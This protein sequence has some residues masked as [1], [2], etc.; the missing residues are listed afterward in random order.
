[1]ALGA[2]IE[3]LGPPCV[4][5]HR[6]IGQV[7]I[8]L[9]NGFELAVAIVAVACNAVAAGESQHNCN[10]DCQPVRETSYRRDSDFKQDRYCGAKLA[11]SG[12][13]QLEVTGSGPVNSKS[14]V[15][16]PQS[17]RSVTARNQRDL[18]G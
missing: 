8:I 3:D 15:A 12:I 14:Q 17:L 7:A 1:M 11:A 9:P 13:R 4:L 18:R 6:T 10:R 5:W 16:R 2:Q